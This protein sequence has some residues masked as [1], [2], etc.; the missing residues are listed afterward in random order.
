MKNLILLIL[1][2]L[3]SITN[4]FSQEAFVGQWFVE[5]DTVETVI[6]YHAE[7]DELRVVVFDLKQNQVIEEK[8]LSYNE[9]MI[10]TSL[11]NPRNGFTAS[12]TYTVVSK[13]ELRVEWI[14]ADQETHIDKYFR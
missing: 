3:S 6:T 12:M 14:D 2:S 13:D 5:G 1:I 7:L 11:V 4:M 10:K 9:N 8:I